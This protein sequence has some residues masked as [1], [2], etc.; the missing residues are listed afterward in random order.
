MD[1]KYKQYFQQI[2]DPAV[3]QHK[4]AYLFNPII[5]V[6]FLQGFAS[7]LIFFKFTIGFLSL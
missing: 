1:Q 5:L 2:H 6:N 3:W 4:C 7:S